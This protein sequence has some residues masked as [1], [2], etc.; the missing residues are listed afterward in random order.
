MFGKIKSVVF[1]VEGMECACCLARIEKAVMSQK[2]VKS[3]VGSIEDRKVTVT[4]KGSVD[5]EAIKKAIIDAGY[6][7]K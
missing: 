1:E 4:F 3:A 2:G 7:V 5:E 6:A